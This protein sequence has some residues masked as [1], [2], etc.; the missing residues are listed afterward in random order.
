MVLVLREVA[1]L[2]ASW[3]LTGS[4]IGEYL[5]YLSEAIAKGAIDLARGVPDPALMKASAIKEAFEEVL[6]DPE[7][8]YTYPPLG[9]PPSL[10]D[11]FRRLIGEYSFE[12][13][14]GYT[15]VVTSGTFAAFNILS[16]LMLTPGDVMV[17]ENPTFT[18]F[19]SQA[20]FY[21]ASTAS[22]P[23]VNGEPSLDTV[24]SH[25]VRAAAFYTI[26]T[27]HNPTGL[28]FGEEWRAGLADLVNEYGLRVIEDM[29][30]SFVHPSPP[31]SPINYVDSE[32]PYA[33]IGSLSKILAP[34]LRIGFAVVPRTWARA[35]EL[36]QLH[37]LSLSPINAAV[38]EKLIRDGVVDKLIQGAR[39]RYT[40]K[41]RAALDTL[42]DR[43]PDWVSWTEPEGGFYLMVYAPG[44][45]MSRLLAEALMKGVAYVP[46]DAFHI[47]PRVAG[48]HT[49]RLSVAVEPVDRIVEGISVL[50]S[51]L[52]DVR[53]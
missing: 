45:D 12:I 18:D 31:R 51:V 40:E 52:R 22:T 4:A 13:P 33:L 28:T 36:A 15:V 11:L 29:T 37:D 20:I 34:G 48:K 1:L 27:L 53:R 19:L 32:A 6:N 10:R 35:I 14:P 50:A 39:R 25:Y 47:P 43:M 2:P 3:R 38:A 9:G 23:I 42:R 49:A 21:G 17:F 7:I 44:A 5:D 30:Y 46:G 24:R 26:P 16:K 41:M 8:P